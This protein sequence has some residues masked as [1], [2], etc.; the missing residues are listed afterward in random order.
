V[1]EAAA[2]S[3]P[4][5]FAVSATLPSEALGF[6]L[7]D[8][9]GGIENDLVKNRLMGDFYQADTRARDHALRFG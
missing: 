1:G 9:R 3:N 7:R 2:V 4:T 8:L 5:N 6:V